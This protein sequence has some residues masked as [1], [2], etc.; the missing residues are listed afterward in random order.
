VTNSSWNDVWFSFDGSGGRVISGTYNPWGGCNGG[1]RSDNV[2]GCTSC[3]FGGWWWG[4][5]INFQNVLAQD[6]WSGRYVQNVSL[7]YGHT[8]M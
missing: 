2:N 4:R 1:I 3:N 7:W 6:N 5:N 8:T